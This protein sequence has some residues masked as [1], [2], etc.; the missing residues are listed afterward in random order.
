MYRIV[1]SYTCLGDN[2]TTQQTFNSNT[3]YSNGSSRNSLKPSSTPP[4]STTPRKLDDEDIFKFLNDT[5]DPPPTTTYQKL[6][7]PAPKISK[8]KKEAPKQPKK[9]INPTSPSQPPQTITTTSTAQETAIT[10]PPITPP[11]P[12][13]QSLPSPKIQSSP[14]EEEENKEQKVDEHEENKNSASPRAPSPTKSPRDSSNSPRLITPADTAEDQIARE[15]KASDVSSRSSEAPEVEVGEEEEKVEATGDSVAPPMEVKIQEGHS[16]NI[17]QKTEE[18]TK[19]KEEISEGDVHP[20][21][22]EGEEEGN[23]SEG[24][25]DTTSLS[26][27]AEFVQKYNDMLTDNAKFGRENKLYLYC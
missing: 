24:E 27:D 23:E 17:D 2:A 12:P 22:E 13:P 26:M 14:R 6:P 16:E 5:N 9:S 4:Q 15:R 18:A 8:S 25:N 7:L 1:V 21:G 3:T 11:S 20:N 19:D 10:V